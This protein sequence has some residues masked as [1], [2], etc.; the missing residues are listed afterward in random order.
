MNQQEE[1]QQQ[2]P[3]LNQ[4][5]PEET[6]GDIMQKSSGDGIKF[7]LI[8]T[9]ALV[10]LAGIVYAEVHGLTMLQN[11]VSPEMRIWANV[12]MIAA[13]I[14]AVILPLALKFWTI[15]AKQRI[16][17]FGFYLLDF[18]FLAFNAFTD[19]NTQQGQQL[20]PWAQTYVTYILPAS[21]IIVAAGW[22]VIWQLDP[23]V[24]QKI[25]V[26]S[27]RAAMKEK[28]ARKVAERA[29]GSNVTERV[30]Q[31]AEQEVERAL[32][33]LFGAPVTAYRMDPPD[34]SPQIKG[35]LKS[36]FAYWLRRAQLA[37]S[38]DTASP[39]N[40]QPSEEPNQP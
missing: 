38:S 33:E 26:L 3:E 13:G 31:A 8:I 2:E 15:E 24:K 9:S 18:A 5:P 20:V 16:A 17:A 32:T 27:L 28:L 25:L 30:T 40:P 19:F 37:Y 1:I 34:E 4:D 29:K 6:V 21:P 12:G 7:W 35:L 23:D 22:S 39:S 10:Y 14:T 11:G 36:F